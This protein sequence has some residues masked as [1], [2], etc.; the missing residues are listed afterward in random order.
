MHFVENEMHSN[1]INSNENEMH[2]NDINSNEDKFI[3]MNINSNISEMY[4][5]DYQFE[6]K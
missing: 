5:N 2:S 6:W 3:R 4:P 1:E